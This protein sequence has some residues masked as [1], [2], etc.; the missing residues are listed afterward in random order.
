MGYQTPQM[1]GNKP[2]TQKKGKGRTSRKSG[3]VKRGN[4]RLSIP[5]T[6]G[7]G[8][9]PRNDGGFKHNDPHGN[10]K[11]KKNKTLHDVQGTRKVVSCPRGRTPQQQN[12]VPWIQYPRTA[13]P[14][15]YAA[16]IRELL[17]GTR[18][19]PVLGE[20]QIDLHGDWGSVESILTETP[21]LRF[22]YRAVVS[23]LRILISEGLV[24][25]SFVEK[26]FNRHPVIG[27]YKVAWSK[28]TDLKD[29]IIY[30][31]DKKP[32]KKVCKEANESWKKQ[33]G[34][35]KQAKIQEQMAE[36]R[37]STPDISDKHCRSIANG[38]VAKVR[39]GITYTNDDG[40]TEV[41]TNKKDFIQRFIL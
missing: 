40:V 17:E 33:F 23:I 20:P 16:V 15:Y 14:V 13:T 11:R 8:V 7:K 39:I 25:M 22:D 36:I 10:H 30:S 18:E 19:N 1:G 29:D 26:V 41:I 24:T 6:D 38:I 4:R 32:S 12:M 28:D 37:Q 5:A 31:R 21:R 35:A 9:H 27:G 3:H 2:T 34:R